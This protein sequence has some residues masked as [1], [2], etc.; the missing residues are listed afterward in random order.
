MKISGERDAMTRVT[1][2]GKK[3]RLDTTTS[4]SVVD[5]LLIFLLK[6]IETK[7]Y[8]HHLFWTRNPSI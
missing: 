2:I 7:S 3:K 6:A 4:R 8:N 1:P 5:I